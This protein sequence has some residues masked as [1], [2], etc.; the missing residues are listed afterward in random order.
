MATLFISSS[1]GYALLTKIFSPSPV[2]RPKF[3]IVVHG[4][5]YNI[6]DSIAEATE[7]GCR[8]A[9]FKGY[10][11]L[12]A[13]G[14]AID[15]VE[16]AVNELENNE[17]FDAGYG[18]VLTRD[19][20]VEMDAIIMDGQTYRTGAVA[21][22]TSV[23]HPIT[24]AKHVMEGT[25][26]TLIVGKGAD[27]FSKQVGMPQ[28]KVEDLVTQIARDEFEKFRE[29]GDTVDNVFNSL[30]VK[31]PQPPQ[32]LGHDTVG[33]VAIDE[34]GNIAAGTSTGGITNKMPGRVGDSPLLG[35]GCYAENCVG[36]VSTTGHGES[37]TKVLLAKSCLDRIAAASK[38][39]ARECIRDA[40]QD[41]QRKVS[42]CGGVICISSDG[43]IITDYST[44]RMCTAQIA[45]FQEPTP[46]K[47]S[48]G[49]V[50][51]SFSNRCYSGIE[52]EKNTW[53][54]HDF[55][56]KLSAR[57]KGKVDI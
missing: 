8:K 40:L 51:T 26:H 7:M 2:K 38:S 25:S 24:L 3:A 4:G 14:S 32:E 50:I 52:R 33:C 55:E 1:L 36:G 23:K 13:G 48:R 17:V 56:Q 19:E 54:T 53:S 39:N 46:Y 22:V 41:M 16:A 44:P 20:G 42:G 11:K 47:N 9:A 49:K 45:H 10:E 34:N 21:C 6:S 27:S 30:S 18:S 15:A 29:Y 57:V 43:E 37:I 31:E 5:A 12:Y 28:V 35:S